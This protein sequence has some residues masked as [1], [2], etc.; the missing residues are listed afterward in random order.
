MGFT[1]S[2]ALL[3]LSIASSWK[4]VP[5]R[6]IRH[7]KYSFGSSCV[8]INRTDSGVGFVSTLSQS[9]IYYKT[10]DLL[11]RYLY[12]TNHNKMSSG[13]N[14]NN[15]G[16]GLSDAA[17]GLNQRTVDDD[18]IIMN[19]KSRIDISIAKSRKIRGSNYVQI[20]TVDHATMEPRCR[21][22]VFRGFMKDVP[23]EN[24]ASYGDCV[25]KM[26]T[27]LR[28]NKVKELESRSSDNLEGNNVEMVWW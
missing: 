8:S 11:S 7:N 15:E 16:I 2:I 10:P 26:I 17:S 24:N 19:W 5:I 22:V 14:A 12:R 1:F 20:S 21:T 6:N 23:L 28:S 3:Q 13:S 25:M 4:S 27:D 9:K 18:S